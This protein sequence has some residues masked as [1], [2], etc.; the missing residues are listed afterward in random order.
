MYIKCLPSIYNKSYMNTIFLLKLDDDCHA[1]AFLQRSNT[2]R[3]WVMAAMAYVNED[4]PF[5]FLRNEIR[6]FIIVRHNISF[7][8]YHIFL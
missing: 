1:T 4:L 2:K 7:F 3:D 5:P 8:T 6:R